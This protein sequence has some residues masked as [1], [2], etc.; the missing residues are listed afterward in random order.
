[1][2]I[3]ELKNP[4]SH[5]LQ[6]KNL[7]IVFN[8]SGAENADVLLFDQASG[9]TKPAGEQKIFDGPGEY[10]VRDTIIEGVQTGTAVSYKIE[11]DGLSLVRLGQ[12][13]AELTDKQIEALSPIDL[14]VIPCRGLNAD[15]VSKLVS[16]L[17]PRIIV[18]IETDAALVKS[19]SSELGVKPESVAKFKVSLKDLPQD[20]QKLV[21]L[22]T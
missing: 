7:T 8:P 3:S 15:Q 21:V 14:L 6:T 16:G 13:T 22:G 2:E 10:E 5:K 17:E 18:P 4:Q 19:L 9:Q 1:M 20:S 12:Q 11:S